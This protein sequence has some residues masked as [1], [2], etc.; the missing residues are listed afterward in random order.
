MRQE[1]R[2]LKAGRYSEDDGDCILDV[3]TKDD[4]THIYSV[5]LDRDIYYHWV[6]DERGKV[7]KFDIGSP[8]EVEA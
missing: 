2:G 1:I 8:F 3:H 7:V 5:D 4:G 6:I